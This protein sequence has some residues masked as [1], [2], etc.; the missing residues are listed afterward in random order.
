MIF[1]LFKKG[2]GMA[3]YIKKAS[4]E[5][6]LFN[7]DKVRQSLLKVRA[8][9]KLI[10]LVL[11]TINREQ[12]KTTKELHNLVIQLLAQY[13]P[14]VA[15]RYN[16][17]RALMELGPAGFPFEQF[18]ARIFAKEGF[19]ITTDIILNGFCVDHEVDILAHKENKRYMIECKFHNRP[20]IKCDIKVPLY[21]QA[22]FEDIKKAWNQQKNNHEI[23]KAWVVTNTKFTAEAIKYG[24]CVPMNLLG[25]SYPPQN[26]LATLIDKYELHPITSLTSLSL[27]QKKQFIQKGFILCKD[28]SNQRDLLRQ[29]GYSPHEIDNIITEAENICKVS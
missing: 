21:V 26:N 15:G 29:F 11:Q 27:R 17:K 3:F 14:A 2:S 16:L 19:D 24:L 1:F 18:V 4:G 10:D 9:Q 22:R 7:E 5:K 6:E 23:H 20:G 12:P 8:D 25:W 28:A 13:E